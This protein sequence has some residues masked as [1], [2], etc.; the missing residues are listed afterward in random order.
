[1]DN[2]AFR[3]YILDS[4]NGYS[5]EIRINCANPDCRGSQSKTLC[6][7]ADSGLYECKRCGIKGNFKNIRKPFHERKAFP[8]YVWDSGWFCDDHPYLK[9]K[10][11]KSHKLKVDKFRRLLIPFYSYGKITTVQTIDN[12]GG[13]KFLPKEKG[14]QAKGAS[15][16]IWGALDRVYVC[17]G[18][19]TG[20]SVYEATGCTVIIVGMKSNFI[21]SL[22]ALRKNSAIQKLFFALTTIRTAAGVGTVS[23]LRKILTPR[24]LCRK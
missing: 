16:I 15:F 18:Y 24:W 9:L 17:E 6:I 14:C 11:A 1:M 23:K 7:N 8:L 22:K 20:A 19:A 4:V 2:V 5:G 10:K 3:N 13:K 12:T 21:P